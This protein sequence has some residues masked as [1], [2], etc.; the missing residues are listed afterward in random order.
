MAVGSSVGEEQVLVVLL[1]LQPRFSQ[2]FFPVIVT[3]SSVGALLGITLGFD[4]TLGIFD[5]I[6][7][8]S[9]LG[10]S[11]GETLGCADGF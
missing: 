7:E 2:S 10:V 3:Q 11:L 9:P 4:D 1:Q 5:G 6:N 8:G